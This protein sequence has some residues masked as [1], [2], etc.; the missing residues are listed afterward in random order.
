MILRDQVRRQGSVIVRL[1]FVEQRDAVAHFLARQ[2]NQN[3]F[4]VGRSD[5]ETIQ[6]E[7]VSKEEFQ[8]LECQEGSPVQLLG[9]KRIEFLCE[10]GL[11]ALG[12]AGLRLNK[13]FE[14]VVVDPVEQIV[15]DVDRLAEALTARP[16]G[17]S[18][19]DLLVPL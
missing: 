14:F 13:T 5:A 2:K 10:S 16:A 1:S 12:A 11:D 4:L 15:I 17:F 18:E 7:I 19:I 6:L 3:M 8:I 9:H